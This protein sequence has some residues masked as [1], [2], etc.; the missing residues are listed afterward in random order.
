D[1]H[2][3]AASNLRANIVFVSPTQVLN[4]LSNVDSVKSLRLIEVLGQ[5]VYQLQ[6]FTNA[7]GKTVVKNQL[8]YATTGKLRPAISRQ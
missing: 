3:K 4:Q 1:H 7:A 5:P 6:Y 8:A 2:R